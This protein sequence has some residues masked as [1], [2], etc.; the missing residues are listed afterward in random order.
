MTDENI[1]QIETLFEAGEG[2]RY[3]TLFEIVIVPCPMPWQLL[4]NDVN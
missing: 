1:F 3:L 2:K 4:Q